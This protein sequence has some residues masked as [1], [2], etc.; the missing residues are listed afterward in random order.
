VPDL[1]SNSPEKLYLPREELLGS[2]SMDV[3]TRGIRNR[4][5]Q[6]RVHTDGEMQ[7]TGWKCRK[8]LDFARMRPDEVLFKAAYVISRSAKAPEESEASCS[9]CLT[10]LPGRRTKNDG[11]Y[12]HRS[13]QK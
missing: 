2:N 11:S 4:S 10:G 12:L 9:R 3:A 8:A 13:Q 6:D 5:S 7:S 1:Q